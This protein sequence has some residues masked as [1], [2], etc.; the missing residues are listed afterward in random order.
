LDA[1]EAER[2]DAAVYKQPVLKIKKSNDI[3][4]TWQLPFATGYYYH[5]HWELGVDFIHMSIGPSMYW[6][7]SDGIVLRFNYSD[8]R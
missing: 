3:P 5:V 1:L 2:D 8:M 7:V 4:G 6:N